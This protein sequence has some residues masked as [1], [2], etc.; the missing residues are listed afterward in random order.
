MQSISGEAFND[1]RGVSP[2]LPHN[3]RC[4]TFRTMTNRDIPLYVRKPTIRWADVIA[5]L[6]AAGF[7]LRQI[8]DALGVSH[9]TVRSWQVGIRGKGPACPNYEDGR[10]L[11]EVFELL[12]PYLEAVGRVA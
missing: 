4:T 9:T 1:R 8:G 12:R 11:L 3:P 6:Q 7:S 10:A 2:G 5:S